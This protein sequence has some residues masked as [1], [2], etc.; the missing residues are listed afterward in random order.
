MA[1]PEVSLLPP[2]DTSTH[3]TL[4]E[5]ER[6]FAA[7]PSS[8]SESGRV[9][10]LS[11]RT[12]DGNRLLPRRALLTANG[13]LTGDRWAASGGEP[14]NQIAAMEA[15]VASLIANGQPLALFGDNL[16]LELDLSSSNLPVGS[17][18]QIGAAELEITP[19]PHDGC[20]KFGARFGGD[21][22]RFVSSRELRPRNLRGI[23]LRVIEDGP[24][25]VGDPIAVLKRGELN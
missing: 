5:L 13:G 21:A 8:P 2:V 3:L 22:L 10:M 4:V 6:R 16:F 23:Y 25:E 24:V 11:A 17:R 9:V 12:D 14:V 18:V 19:F 1:A 15:P 7:L 20:H